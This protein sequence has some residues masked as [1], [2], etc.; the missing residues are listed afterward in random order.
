MSGGTLIPSTRA[1]VEALRRR[2]RALGEFSCGREACFV[3]PDQLGEVSVRR[4]TS[5]T[6]SRG[7]LLAL[8]DRNGAQ[9]TH[10]EH[11]G[12]RSVIPLSFM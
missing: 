3:S 4:G 2:L 1:A 12:I 10:E 9:F 5:A 11:F 6:L 8:K 7:M